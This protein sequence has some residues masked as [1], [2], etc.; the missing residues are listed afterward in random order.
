MGWG[1]GGAWVSRCGIW[2]ERRATRRFSKFPA[3]RS[4]DDVTGPTPPFELRSSP[5]RGQRENTGRVGGESFCRGSNW[6]FFPP[7]FLL[8]F[9]ANSPFPLDF[10]C[11]VVTNV[12]SS[13]L[14]Y[15]S[16]R[17]FYIIREVWIKIFYYY[18]LIIDECLIYN[19]YEYF[20]FFFKYIY[21]KWIAM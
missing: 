7:L 5:R 17:I 15:Y 6:I 9:S 3:P 12:L 2:V 1:G 8:T 20:F 16:W 4:C 19:V 21:L 10:Q 18:F 13:F 14:N 11:L